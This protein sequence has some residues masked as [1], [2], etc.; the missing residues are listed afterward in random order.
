MIHRYWTGSRPPDG[1]TYWPSE[2]YR[3]TDDDIP[4]EL[5]EWISAR[6]GVV[7]DD[8]LGRHRA[9]LVRWWLLWH[10]G[11]TWLD[12]DITVVDW[13]ALPA[14]PWVSSWDGQPEPGAASFPAH[15][16]LVGAILTFLN[17][18]PSDP[19]SLISRAWMSGPPNVSGANVL[20]RE[21]RR[22]PVTLVPLEPGNPLRME[23]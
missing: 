20:R 19:P 4:A 9:N 10:H 3:W 18:S 15:H 21:F 22:R 13:Q 14:D 11:G 5:E 16:P 12:Y 1:P 6:R 23:P 17:R 2:E 8:D 7:P